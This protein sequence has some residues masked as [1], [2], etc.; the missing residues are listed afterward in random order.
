MVAGRPSVRI[1][2]RWAA[3]AVVLAVLGAAIVP[4]TSAGAEAGSGEPDLAVT[5]LKGYEAPGTPEDLNRVGVIKIGPAD[6]KNVLVLVPGTS[7]GSGYFVPLARDVV[8]AND[9]WQVWSVERRENQ[10]EDHSV[11][12]RAKRGRAESQEVFNYYLGYLT[13]S[14][15]DP[16]HEPVEDEAVPYARDWGMNVTVEDLH[17]VVKAAGKLGGDVVL[18]GHS[19]GGTITTAYAT[20]DF[21]GKAG[22]E[23]LAGLVYIDGGSN[24]APVT[25]EEATFA[26]EGLAGGSPWLSFGGIPAP[27]AGVFGSLGGTSTIVDPDSLGIAQNWAAFPGNL[28]APVQ[29]TNEAQFGYALDAETS[30]MGLRAAQ[31]NAGRLAESGDPRGWDRSGEITPIQRFAAMFSGI[32]VKSADGVAWYHPQRLTIDGRAVAAGNANPA[33]DVLDVHATH[34][35]AIDVPIYAFGA[36]LGGQRVLDAATAL[37]TQ[38]GLPESELTLINRETTYTHNDPSSASPENEFLDELLPFLK[39]IAR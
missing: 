27:L 19:L 3:I 22:V 6:A 2:S 1:R 33:Q 37:A 26:L 34:G 39:R 32:D 28:K 20:W 12:N 10:F 9:D 29:V 35:D 5:W 23:N 7:A 24:P 31:V 30:P 8:E 4:S 15:V 38:S 14:T 21:D 17:R 16:H 36:A 25:P 13:D 18:G 11:I